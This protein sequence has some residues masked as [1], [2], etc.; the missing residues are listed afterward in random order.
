MSEFSKDV[1]A[2]LSRPQKRLSS[3]Y[4]YDDVGSRIFQE[5]MDME[6]YYLTDCEHE[7]LSNSSVDI[8]KALGFKSHFNII[9]LGPGDGAKTFHFLKYLND[10]AI[11]C[12]YVPIDISGEAIDQLALDLKSKLPNLKVK[13]LVGDYFEVLEGEYAGHIDPSLLLFLGSNI[14]NYQGQEAVSLLEHFGREML[15]G[16]KLLIGIDLQ[17]NPKII[18]HAYY[19]PAGVTKSFNLNLLTRINRELKADFDIPNFDFFCHYNPLNGEV[20]SYL[21]SLSEQ[22]VH[23]DDHQRTYHFKENELIWT[24]LSKKYTLGEISSLAKQSGYELLD[25]FI[26]KRKYFVDSLWEKT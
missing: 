24:E 18:H 15:K 21:V 22:S 23:I 8:Y 16:D 9:E 1:E 17:K 7:I 6:E 13:P 11:D 2:G 4:F 19:D 3:K 5:I 12:T 14:G 26:D 10:N 25:N 20:R